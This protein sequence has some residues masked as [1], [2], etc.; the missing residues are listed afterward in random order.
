MNGYT[1]SGGVNHIATR[2]TSVG[3]SYVHNPLRLSEAF[4]RL[5]LTPS[6][7]PT[8]PFLAAPG[9]SPERRRIHRRI[10][11]LQAVTL[12]PALAALF[13]T[14]LVFV[15]LYTKSTNSSGYVTGA[16]IQAGQ[17]SFQYERALTLAM[18]FIWR[19]ASIVER[20]ASAI[21]RFG[22]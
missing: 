5:T 18:V 8:G 15:P 19:P 12:D 1:P 21:R 22:N 14:K 10:T 17:R 6:K 9:H 11:H 2:N 3:V 13:G 20:P 16:A 7:A 4:G